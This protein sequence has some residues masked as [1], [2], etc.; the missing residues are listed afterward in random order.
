[1]GEYI[2]FPKDYATVYPEGI[3]TQWMDFEE[4]A[5]LHSI[6]FGYRRIRDSITSGDKLTLF[7]TSK[8]DSELP[9]DKTRILSVDLYFTDHAVFLRNLIYYGVFEKDEVL[10]AND[11]VDS[12]MMDDDYLRTV[13]GYGESKYIGRVAN[14]LDLKGEVAFNYEEFKAYRG[15]VND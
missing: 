6:I 7:F 9:A 3:N 15:R 14:F 11:I 1:M 10:N 12:L 13:L 8:V 2:S 5:E 4:Y